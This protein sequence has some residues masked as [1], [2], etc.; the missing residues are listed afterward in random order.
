[1]KKFNDHDDEDIENFD[2]QLENL[3][4][5]FDLAIDSL[6]GYLTPLI[7]KNLVDIKS[8]PP[9]SKTRHA[10]IVNQ[11]PEL[12]ILFSTGA[13]ELGVASDTKR[14]MGKLRVVFNKMLVNTETTLDDLKKFVENIKM[15]PYN[16]ENI[17]DDYLQ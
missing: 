1:M 13:L 15:I 10:K 9:V 5:E 14:V 16:I 12:D 4:D 7:I 2:A 8:A 3:I 6:E 11:F 17:P